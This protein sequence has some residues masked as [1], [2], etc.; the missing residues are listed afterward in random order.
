MLAHFL[1]MWP[2]ERRRRLEA[3]TSSLFIRPRKV[4]AGFARVL[5]G[6]QGKVQARKTAKSLKA[7]AYSG[8]DAGT[9]LLPS[10]LREH[11]CPGDADFCPLALAF[12]N[13]LNEVVVCVLERRIVFDFPKHSAV[14][15]LLSF[16]GTDLLPDVGSF[17][18]FAGHGLYKFP[19]FGICFDV[20]VNLSVDA[21][22][23]PEL[24]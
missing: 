20:A 19:T 4:F 8:S 22:I 7:A 5:E 6:K 14:H 2:R 15:F 24:E 17:Q 1:L 16:I 21:R 12:G 11:E 3:A 18:P 10:G 13:L 23:F 9:L